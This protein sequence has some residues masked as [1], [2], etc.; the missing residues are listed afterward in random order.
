MTFRPGGL[1]AICVGAVLA[2]AS[3]PATIAQDPPAD[4][5]AALEQACRDDGGEPAGCACSAGVLA[6]NLTEREMAAA[7]IMFTDPL[8]AVD[9][10]AAIA[11]L[12]DAGYGLDEIAAVMERIVAL[13]GAANDEC[14]PP[15]DEPN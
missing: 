10:G 11:T 8:G 5:R 1:A 14:A 4:P 13:E 3:A 6:D 15:P 2:A 9:P 7:A 12:R